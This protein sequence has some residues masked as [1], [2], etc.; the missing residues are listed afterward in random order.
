MTHADENGIVTCIDGCGR[1]GF[2][3]D[4]DCGHFVDRDKLPTRWDM[5]N[6]RPQSPVCNRMKTGK[7]YEFGRALNQE[8]PGL[9]DRLLEKGDGP[10]HEIRDRAPAML[11]EIR[12]KLKEQR[13][14]LK[15][16]TR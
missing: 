2:W 13:K 5:D 14:R 11:L 8:N 6:C 15:G 10:G 7:R 9:A 12:A 4:F 3:K 1:S 16:V